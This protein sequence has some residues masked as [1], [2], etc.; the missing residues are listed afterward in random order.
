MK[1]AVFLDRDGVL[2]ALDYRDGG[3][4]APLSLASFR[5]FPSAADAVRR[6]HAAG[7][8]CLVITNQPDVG[9]GELDPTVLSAMHERLQR[10]TGVDAIYVCPHVD[11]DDCDCRKPRPGLLRRAAV[12][13][14]V[15]LTA[16]FLVGDRGRD[17][18]AGEAVGCTTVL[19][20]GT[21]EPAGNPQFRAATLADAVTLIL[22]TREAQR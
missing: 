15:E 2:N 8:V 13:F 5:L 19:V 9:T 3:W 12:D 10:E 22:E 17:I 7:F 11:A 18:G 6:L 20:E 14:N 21:A 1:Q 4:R 16:S